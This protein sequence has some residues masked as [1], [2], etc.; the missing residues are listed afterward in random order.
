VLTTSPTH[1]L[2]TAYL[3]GRQDLLSYV[4]RLS[5]DQHRAEDI[6]QD[7]ALRILE[8]A[9]QFEGRGSAAGWLRTTARNTFLMSIRAQKERPG[10]AGP[11]VV[12]SADEEFFERARHRQLTE[13]L[14]GCLSAEERRLVDLYY[15]EGLSV[16]GVARHLGLSVTTVKTRLFRLRR[17]LEAHLDPGIVECRR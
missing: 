13:W 1:P 12:R 10:R 5:G 9:E 4:R 16:G 17:R 7:V 15:G 6:V 11:L 8:K 3:D 14:D 2:W